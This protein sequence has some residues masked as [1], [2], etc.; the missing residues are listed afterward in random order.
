MARRLDN[1]IG[2]FLDY[3][4]GIESPYRFRLWAG[5]STVSAA[6]GRRISVPIKGQMQH[7]NLYIILVGPVG[8]GKTNAIKHGR[9]LVEKLKVVHLTPERLTRQA[10]Y[11]EIEESQ[12]T[13]LSLDNSDA[14][15]AAA[16]SGM[17]D[18]MNVFLHRG[19]FEFMDELTALYD[20]PPKFKYKTRTSGKSEAD[21]VCFNFIA[22]TTPRGIRETFTDV[23]FERG[24]PSRCLLIWADDQ[25]N[26][27]PFK[28]A[29]RAEKFEPDL[30]HD[31]EAISRLQG[32]YMWEDAAIDYIR[33][34]HNKELKPKP[35][36]PRFE[37]Y[38]TRRLAHFTKL[39]LVLAASRHDDPII[40]LED[41]VAAKKLLEEAEVVMPH[42]IS[43]AGRNTLYDSMKIAVR[44]IAAEGRRNGGKPVEDYKIREVINRDVPVHMMRPLFQELINNRWVIPVGEKEPYKY[45]ANKETRDS[46]SK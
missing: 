10:F 14:I 35:Q 13:K 38:N 18:E 4:A 23:V 43:S 40:Y 33:K 8:T 44:V 19:D 16:F 30:Y 2:G 5:I 6:L 25:P 24:L 36:D 11:D 46:W 12:E 29:G 39:S 37:G 15:R 41:I 34:W 7:A 21:N 31:L 20:N 42:C 32:E 22:G 3:T 26:V 9:P 1:W 45:I 28:Y 17:V 27:D